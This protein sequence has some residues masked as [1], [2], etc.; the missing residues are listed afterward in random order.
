MLTPILCKHQT[1]S[2]MAHVTDLAGFHLTGCFGP[3]KNKN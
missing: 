3:M 1:H 2:A